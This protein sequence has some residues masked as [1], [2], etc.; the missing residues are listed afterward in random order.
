MKTVGIIGGTGFVGTHLTDLLVE[1]G[2]NVIVFSRGNHHTPATGKPVTYSIWDAAKQACDPAAI[3]K[4]DAVV[5]LAGA[6]VADKRWT[7]ARKQEIIDSRVN[8]TNFLISMLRQHA[9]GCKTF[10][11]ASA[12]GFYGPDHPAFHA[13]TE[14]AVAYNDFLGNTCKVWEDASNAAADSI[15]TTILRTGIV[16]GKESGAFLEFAKPMKF[17]IMPIL[18]SGKQ[19]ISWIEVDDLA[20][21]YLYAI[22]NQ[23]ISGIYNAVAPS[24]VS[25]KEMMQT[26]AGI[27]GGIKIPVYVPEFVLKIMLGEMSIEVLKSCNASA[28]KIL[29]A[30]F[31]FNY[32]ELPAAV[33]KILGR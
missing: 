22:E 8:S 28:Q 2:Y 21:L 11:A 24:P 33:R 14:D 17:G 15:R 32:P 6:G 5:H 4:L 20:R 31:S 10:V 26:I 7:V 16:L 30:G 13:F 18:G 12:T 9:P 1:K 23:A 27:M 19:N 29:N 3:A 25:N